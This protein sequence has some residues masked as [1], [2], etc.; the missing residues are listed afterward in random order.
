MLNIFQGIV[1][2]KKLNDSNVSI[3][4]IGESYQ[5]SENEASSPTNN[6]VFEEV[7]KNS[8]NVEED[9]EDPEMKMLREAVI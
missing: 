9:E 1:I 8:S 3:A 6:Q 5:T 2:F 4:N 7:A